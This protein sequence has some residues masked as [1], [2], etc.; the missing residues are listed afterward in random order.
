[1]ATEEALQCQSYPANAD[2]STKQYYFVVVNSSGNAA[3]AG[4]GNA[5]GVLQNAPAAAGRAANVAIGGRTKVVCGGT[6]N[7]GDRVTSDSSGKCVAVGSGEIELGFCV[8][9]G[10]SGVIASIVLQRGASVA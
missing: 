6:I 1:M 7:P 9:A 10:T 3:V 8:E 4:A 5:M 2:L